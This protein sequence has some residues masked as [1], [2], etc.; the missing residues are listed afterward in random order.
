MSIKETREKIEVMQAWCDN[1]TIQIKD[2]GTD[3]WRPIGTEYQGAAQPSWDWTRS[4]YRIKP[5]PRE[6]W[7]RSHDIP[8]SGAF[9]V[10]AYVTDTEGTPVERFI[11]VREVTDEEM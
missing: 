2:N 4:T 9:A 11:K 10:N 3:K 5:K 7:I 8:E 6:F 1:E